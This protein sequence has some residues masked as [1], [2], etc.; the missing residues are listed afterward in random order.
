MVTGVRQGR[1]AVYRA[2]LEGMRWLIEYLL[3]DCCHGD[4]TF[5]ATVFSAFN[6]A[7]Y[8]PTPQQSHLVILFF[9]VLG[10]SPS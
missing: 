6:K 9:N 4:V 2:D 3:A 10:D 7:D 8:S 5:C 1:S